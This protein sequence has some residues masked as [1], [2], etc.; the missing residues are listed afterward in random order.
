MP[1]H[2]LVRTLGQFAEKLSIQELEFS[3]E[4]LSIFSTQ[5]A[6]FKMLMYL[7]GD[8]IHSVLGVLQLDCPQT[9]LPQVGF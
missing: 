3:A 7:G 5:V 9:R 6:G 1:K 4:A 2:G 8:L